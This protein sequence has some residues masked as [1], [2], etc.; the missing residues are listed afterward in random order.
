MQHHHTQHYPLQL[1]HLHAHQHPT[2]QYTAL[3]P[4]HNNNP[5]LL[6][7]HWG[8]KR[9]PTEDAGDVTIN[10]R[11][12]PTEASAQGLFGW[13]DLLE[14]ASS[15][16]PGSPHSSIESSYGCF[17]RHP[18]PQS[19]PATPPIDCDTPRFVHDQGTVSIWQAAVVA[20]SSRQRSAA[21]RSPLQHSV[22]SA[23]SS[24]GGNI[25]ESSGFSVPR[26]I[27]DDN[28]LV[29]PIS[30][31]NLNLETRSHSAG[32]E[33][34]TNISIEKTPSYRPNFVMG[35]KPGCEKCQ[36]REK[37]HFAHFE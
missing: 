20:E 16:G 15:P 24:P 27:H 34:H 21:F 29:Q 6:P 31:S 17:E 5:S 13:D 28:G 37:G 23:P 35:F 18:T 2:A 22:S 4:D 10:K 32:P 33:S 7:F 8:R 9:G 36:R 12:K 1:Q 11:K 3:L 30:N 14:A 26:R 19:N 25:G